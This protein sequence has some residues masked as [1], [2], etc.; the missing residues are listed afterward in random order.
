MLAFHFAEFAVF[1]D[2]FQELAEAAVLG[3]EAVEGGAVDFGIDF[4]G[5]DMR[6]C[7]EG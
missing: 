2:A 4:G 5:G 1:G 3:V 6:D 7:G